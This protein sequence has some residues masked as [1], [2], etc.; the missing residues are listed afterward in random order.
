[1]AASWKTESGDLKCRWPEIA[2]PVEQPA[3]LQ[4]TG[5]QAGRCLGGALEVIPDFAS[6]S[7]FGGG[8]DWFLLHRGSP[9]SK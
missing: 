2:Q 3:W 5:P 9:G 7:P 4:Q 8:T 1:M 6:H